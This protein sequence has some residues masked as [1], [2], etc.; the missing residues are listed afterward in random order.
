MLLL[1]GAQAGLSWSTV[2]TKIREAF[3]SFDTCL[4]DWVK[5]APS[6]NHPAPGDPLRPGRGCRCGSAALVGVPPAQE[7]ART[8]MLS[9]ARRGLAGVARAGAC[10]SPDLSAGAGPPA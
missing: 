6:V 4:W 2:L 10:G 8:R 3:G 9:G 7:A 5:G 1:E